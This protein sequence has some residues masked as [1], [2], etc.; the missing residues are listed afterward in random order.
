[1]NKFI[2]N[3]NIIENNKCELSESESKACELNLDSD[4]CNQ[5][6]LKKEIVERNCIVSENDTDLYPTLDDKEFNVKIASKPEFDECDLGCEINTDIEAFADELANEEVDIA[7]QQEFVKNF[8][9]PETPYNSLLLYHGTGTGKTCSALGVSEE[10]RRFMKKMG[11]LKKI[12]IV[13]PKNVIENFRVQLFNEKKLEQSNGVWSVK[14]C[15]GNKILEELYPGGTSGL[16]KEDILRKV[17]EIIKENYLFFTFEEFA[18]FLT[19]NNENME[20]Q[21]II[22]DEVHNMKLPKYSRLADLFEK[23]VKENRKL[24]LLF[25]SA[26]PMY[27]DIEEIIWLLNILNINDVRGKISY[28]DIFDSEGNITENGKELLIRKSTGYVSFVKGEN[29]YIFPYR[30]YPSIF[31][32]SK[33]F[34]QENN[35]PDMQINEKIINKEEPRESQYINNIATNL[36]LNKLKSCDQNCGFCQSCIYSLVSKDFKTME[37]LTFK[38]LLLP[39]QCLNMTF[40][41]DSIID[42]NDFTGKQGLQKIMD[43]QD[44]KTSQN[45]IKGN[46]NYKPDI[47]EKYGRIFSPEVIG[48][49]S[50]KIKSIIE[51]ISKPAEGIILIH[52]QFIDS[53]LIPIALTL[54]EMGFTRYNHKNLFASP[55]SKQIDARTLKENETD[56]IPAKYVILSGDQRLSPNNIEDLKAIT[57]EDNKNGEKI[58]IVLISKSASEGLDF[59]NIRQVYLL[60]PGET[61]CL[62]EQVIG[63]AV[64]SFSHKDLPFEKRNVQIF[65][66]ATLLEKEESADLYLYRQAGINAIQIGKVS[67]I[68]KQSAVDC[69]LNQSQ[70]NF[71]QEKMNGIVKQVLADN[72]IIQNFKVGDAPFSA[73]CDYMDTCDYSCIPNKT[74]EKEENISNNFLRVNSNEIIEKIRLL[75]KEEYFYKKENLLKN[76]NLNKNYSILQIYSALSQLIDNENEYIE[77]KYGRKGKLINVGDYYL[78]QPVEIDN[79]NI[80]V[81]ERSSPIDMKAEVIQ[82]NENVLQKENKVFEKILENMKFENDSEINQAIFWLTQH[83]FEKNV[84]ENLV[85]QSFIDKLEFDEK[86]ELLTFAFEKNNE[87]IK[88]YFLKNIIHTESFD[89]LPFIENNKIEFFKYD[90]NS[91]SWKDL[92]VNEEKYLKN[93]FTKLKLAKFVGHFKFYKNNFSFFINNKSCE[94][95]S[96]ESIMQEINALLK[97]TILYSESLKTNKNILCFIE[98]LIL[99]YFQ[100]IEK[101]SLTWFLTP[102]RAFIEKM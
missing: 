17:N 66:F 73:V 86:F 92:E 78:F 15:N 83:N 48:K 29:P 64:R 18:N 53:G 65:L 62:S 80:S 26:T 32:I 71:A 101:D 6:L 93:N 47:V 40:P 70:I 46:F 99:R 21:M 96:K 24:K 58:K 1:M 98:E 4:E 44:E 14:G 8:L 22:I 68:L 38:K 59:K 45:F 75:M 55:P 81:F 25:L 52:S 61:L 97:E 10:T 23:T 50:V 63:R 34:G 85:L 19:K 30:I 95:K 37:D 82:F 36:Y 56:L 67:R 72:K 91:S 16:K 102:E 89:A 12:I 88:E 3:E 76:I 49:Y 74:I 41:S 7:P 33:T 77:D 31:D 9:S 57:N 42:K 43:F 5:F 60:E 100:L 13:A 90:K 84:L 94:E 20:N 28:N 11:D 35:Y 69:K 51:N 87:E 54:E 39:L 27:N 79:K 2:I